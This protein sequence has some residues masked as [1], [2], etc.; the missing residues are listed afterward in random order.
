MF[1]ILLEILA[2]YF[3]K[4]ALEKDKKFLLLSIF[5]M[6]LA[7]FSY[8]GTVGLFV[9]IS[10]IYVIRY[11]KN[12]K[13]FLLNNVILGIVYVVPALVNYGIV[14]IFFHNARVS[15]GINII[16][17]ISRIFELSKIYDD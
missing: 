11:S 14:K 2:V 7:N 1:S 17:S 3:F 10:A 4:K 5:M 15:G 16:K 9:V 13:E 12:I 8:Q 6:L